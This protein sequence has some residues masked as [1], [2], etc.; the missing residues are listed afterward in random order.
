MAL[1]VAGLLLVALATWLVYRL[2]AHR[3]AEPRSHGAPVAALPRVPSHLGAMVGALAAPG[4][5]GDGAACSLQDNL[6]D[7]RLVGVRLRHIQVVAQ[8]TAAGRDRVLQGDRFPRVDHLI[9]L[10][11]IDELAHGRRGQRRADLAH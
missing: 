5:A 3:G 8:S 6:L 1:L 7:I 2:D 9:G 10:P 4:C 11:L